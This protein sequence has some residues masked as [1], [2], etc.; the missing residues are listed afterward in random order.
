VLRGGLV[1]VELESVGEEKSKGKETGSNKGT[2][3]CAFTLDGNC[4]MT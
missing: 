1:A 3:P 4:V 2:S